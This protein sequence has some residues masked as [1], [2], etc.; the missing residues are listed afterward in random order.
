[1]TLAP[2]LEPWSVS[3][4]PIYSLRRANV[5]MQST[6]AV[7]QA[8]GRACPEP[9]RRDLARP[10]KSPTEL[11]AAPI[12]A[13]AEKVLHGHGPDFYLF[14]PPDALSSSLLKTCPSFIT[15]C[16]LS[17]ALMS[18]NGSPLTATIS[19]NAPGATTPILPSTSSITAAREV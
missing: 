13:T 16:T 1:M 3:S 5:V 17:S 2:S 6:E 12:T 14:S 18:R 10:A 19:A 7:F 11:C 9:S 8:Q 15:N 4:Q